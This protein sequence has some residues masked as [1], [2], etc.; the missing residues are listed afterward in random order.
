MSPCMGLFSKGIGRIREFNIHRR[1]RAAL[2]LFRETQELERKFASEAKRFGIST[3]DLSPKNYYETLGLKYTSDPK[4]IKGAYVGLVKRYHPDIN[5]SIEATRKT[6]EI[7]EAYA[8]L[9][10]KKKKEE[11]D[12]KSSKGSSKIS[13][14][15]ART[16]SNELLGRYSELRNRDYEEFNKRVAVPQYRDSLKAAIEEV[17][18]W[19]KRFNKAESGILGKFRDY[20]SRISHMAAINRSLVKSAHDEQSRER[21]RENL[22]KLEGMEKAYQEAEKGIAAVIEKLKAEISTSENNIADRLRRSVN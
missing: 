20:G 13:V 6:T 17:A 18:D 15:T 22:V 1:E 8:V 11:Y 21:L 12:A 19:N 2:S 7:N 14:E 9:K 16:I 4:A 3:N 10:D 5:K